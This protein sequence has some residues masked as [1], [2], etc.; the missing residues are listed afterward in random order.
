MPGLSPIVGRTI[1]EAEEKLHELEELTHPV[2][3]REILSTQLGGFDLAP[4]P[5]DGPLPELPPHDGINASA[6]SYQKAI[7]TLPIGSVARRIVQGAFGHSPELAQRIV[8]EV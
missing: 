8:E 6:S 1:A 2:V 7:D 3:L 5:F 4:Y